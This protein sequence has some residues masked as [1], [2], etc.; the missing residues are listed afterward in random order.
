MF[1]EDLIEE[2]A[3]ISGESV[4]SMRYIIGDSPLDSNKDFI[5]IGSSPNDEE[6]AQLNLENAET[7]FDF[8][9]Q[10]HLECIVLLDQIQ[11]T[12][13]KDFK[14]KD[15]L[16]IKKNNYRDSYYEEVAYSFSIDEEDELHI[17]LVETS[18]PDYWDKI[19]LTKLKN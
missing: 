2:L 10:N 11:R 15:Q 17:G 3:F 7:L 13:L 16:F 19:S 5:I 8:H 14:F 6:C 18:L 1:D 9:K 4:N 12:T